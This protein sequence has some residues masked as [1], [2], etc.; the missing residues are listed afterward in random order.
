MK[1]KLSRTGILVVAL[2]GL[3]LPVTAQVD[4]DSN[5]F[6][7]LR[8]R[9]IGPAVMSGRIAALD[10]VP[11]DPLTIY[12][13]AASGGV[14]KSKDAG[15]TWNPVFDDYNQSIGAIRVDPQNSDIVWVG[16]GESWVRN[17]VS[18]GD[19]VYKS[20][21]AGDSWE[22]VGLADSER[23]ARIVIDPEETDT[24][25]VCATGQLWSA[26]EERG[27]YKTTDG[28]ENWERVL[29]V[30][31][32]T[33]CS[34][35]TIDP[36]SPNILYAGMWQFRRYPDFFESGG[37]GSALYKSTDG[38]KSWKEL[39]TGLPQG[40]KGRIAVAVAPSRPSR[41]YAVVEADRTALFKSDD[42]GE[43]WEEMNSSPAVSARPFYFAYLVVDPENF[44]RVYKPGF[45]LGI[46]TDSGRSFSSMFSGGFSM[47]VHS[48]HHALW[49]NPEN[50]YEILLGTDGGIYI[51]SDRATHFRLV[52]SLPVS[53]FYEVSADMDWPYNVYGGL[54][55]NSAWMGPSRSAGGIENKD[56]RP[57]VM[58]DGF[59]TYR[60]P[61]E[62]DIVYVEYQ[63]GMLSRYYLATGQSKEI[64]P[65]PGEGESDYRF[66]W[67]AP[68]L[69][70]PSTPGVL[71]FGGQYLFRSTDRGES[72]EKISP[73]LTTDDPQRQ[74]QLE[75]GGLTI[76]N[77]TAEN[78]ATIY[79]ISESPRNRKVLWVGTDDGLVQV[80]RDG[81]ESW[82][83]VTASI[84]DLPEGL[85]VSHVEASPH[86]EGTAHI[87][88]D[89]HRSGDMSTYL[90]RTTDFGQSW[91]SIVGEGIESFAHVVVQDLVNPELLFA[92][93][94]YGLYLTLDAG[95]R[96]ARFKGGLPPVPVRDV[97]I[98]PREHDLIIGTH[99]RGIYILDDLTPLRALTAE[100]LEAD[101]ALLPA[102]DAVMEASGGMG[103]FTGH[104]EFVGQN[105]PE[106]ASIFFY[107]KKRHIFGDLKIEVY[108]SDDELIT[109]IPA[110]KVRGLNR[111][112]WPMRLPPPKLPPA[113]SL[114]MAFYGPRVLE[115]EYTF[116][117]I[118]GK[119]TF[120][121]KVNLVPDPR[122]PHS[123]E[124]RKLQQETALELYYALED[125]TYLID[126]L[127]DVRDQA[128][129]RGEEAGGKGS[130]FNKLEAYAADVEVFRGSLVST[131]EG[132]MISGDEKLREQMGNLFGGIVGY[133]GRPTRSQLD[134]KDVLIKELRTA[135]ARFEE[136]TTSRELSSLNS[137]LQS[138]SLEMIGVMSREEWEESQESSGSSSG[139]STK[140]LAGIMSSRALMP[141]GF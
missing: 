25:Y 52:K 11:G 24:V 73:D 56:W 30:D 65:L 46:S 115:G 106:A 126:T 32:D 134:R 123:A 20:T 44:E 95:N 76:D 16:T 21:D 78:N 103:W 121:G 82:T 94:E 92:G 75:T 63:G 109:T 129:A 6:G 77:S 105:P 59:H 88:V 55:D 3:G 114:V 141:L 127:I 108:D 42:L 34:D 124:D 18:I 67:N 23:I 91:E 38:G 93:T 62:T 43:S 2:L 45:S 87:S 36:Q 66:N 104:D 107:Q 41:V 27:V 81:G 58:G 138:R 51:S 33:G 4:I 89:G 14:W 50:P 48:D 136:L 97:D 72:W 128:K 68:L 139:V 137:Q 60:D 131:A 61:E 40:E 71:Y 110:P 28:G 37:P 132:G 70:S 90:Y 120:E 135:E 8:A 57:L 47:A 49:I 102:R 111:A 13:G 96:W 98:H 17:S 85:W 22:F 140:R 5:T 122:S 1:S 31:E 69:L 86:E 12:A 26:N 118:K 100:T 79:T 64:R 83:N 113:T 19:G 84:P 39:T 35:I 119:D 116:K 80:T 130:L 10:A 117:L 125:L 7:G 15:T 74:R 53:Q 9:S 29:W 54:Q 133:D 112:E 101:L 99:G